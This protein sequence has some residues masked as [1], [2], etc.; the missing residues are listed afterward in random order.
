MRFASLPC[1]LLAGCF[2]I[3]SFATPL[4]AAQELDG[5]GERRA[6]VAARAWQ[7]HQDPPLAADLVAS[8]NS[9]EDPEQLLAAAARGLR[10]EAALNALL[11]AALPHQFDQAPS[12]AMLELLE[13]APLDETCL[14]R[15]AKAQSSPAWREA[16]TLALLRGGMPAEALDGFPILLET[17]LQDGWLPGPQVAASFFEDPQLRARMWPGIVGKSASPALAGALRELDSQSWSAGD[18]LLLAVLLADAQ[19][20]SPASAD[21]LWKGWLMTPL[22]EAAGVALQA[23][24]AR[25]LPW[26]DPST[27]RATWQAASEKRQQDGLVLLSLL[28]PAP[29]AGMLRELALDPEQDSSLRARA[30]QAVMRCG[31]DVDVQALASL[32]QS[33]TP[34]PILQ[35]LLAGFRLRPAAGIAT[36]LESM[37][38]RLRTRLASLAIE[39]IVL[40]GNQEARLRWLD[41]LGPLSQSDQV[42]IVQAAWA[43]GA[44]EELL[45]WFRAQASSPQ[46]DAALRGRVGLQAAWTSAE[47][48]AFYGNQLL[49]ANNAEARQVVL[50]S[51]RELRND[52]ALEVIVDWLASEEGL[53]HPSSASWA[54][55]VIEE[56]QAARAF[57]GWWQNPSQLNPGQADAAASNLMDEVETARE[58]IRERIPNVDSAVQ[59][60]MLSA[61]VR[62]PQL[63]D[64]EL[65]FSLLIDS[66]AAEPVR[67][68]AAQIAG[69]LSSGDPALLERCWQQLL[70]VAAAQPNSPLREYRALIRAYSARASVTQRSQL[71]SRIA[72]LGGP[73]RS[74]LLVEVGLGEATDP[75][76]ESGQRAASEVIRELARDPGNTQASAQ[77]AEQVLRRDRTALFAAL[78]ILSAMGPSDSVEAQL[79]RGLDSLASWNPD[80]LAIAA[81]SLDELAPEFADAARERLRRTESANSWRQPPRADQPTQ[82]W[83]HSANEAFRELE[84]GLLGDAPT[85]ML[86]LDVCVM[87]WPRDRRSHLWA[88]WYALREREYLAAARSFTQAD[89]CSG[90]LPYARMEP[91]LGL[92]LCEWRNTGTL[93][94]VQQLIAKLPQAENLLAVR[95]N[96]QDRADLEAAREG[97]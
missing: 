4:S 55:L 52:E 48:A 82:A 40:T 90:W 63:A 71:Q 44:S 21:T 45:D 38:P 70:S 20:P 2:A 24:L 85:P 9:T 54:A 86:L 72:A 41:R 89:Q 68:R 11:A 13:S 56:T 50:R 73:W 78:S 97:E 80:A 95:L 29:A 83:M 19:Q 75:D 42:R 79:V 96:A 64:F 17:A 94:A 88:G 27:L 36:A 31:S 15:L 18:Q 84:D 7:L 14:A 8:W 91:R 35:S 62:S 74:S 25:H 3:G 10:G 77:L 6:D 57:R 34:Q 43:N 59:I 16:A 1:V 5:A 39:L 26:A 76:E 47:L 49:Q 30:V 32:L 23:A 28:A 81:R 46:V 66:A 37:M 33:D 69:E 60:R 12:P 51:V 65:A 61:M 58:Y 92:A 53:R 22:P 67:S 93:Q 87:R